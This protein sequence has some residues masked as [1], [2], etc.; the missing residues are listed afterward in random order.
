MRLTYGDVTDDTGIYSPGRFTGK[1]LTA[2]SMLTFG[3]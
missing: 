2:Y 3:F 1:Q